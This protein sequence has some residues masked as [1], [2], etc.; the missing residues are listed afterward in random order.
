MPDFCGSTSRSRPPAFTSAGDAEKSKSGPSVSGQFGLS[1]FFARQPSVQVSFG[2][3]CWN[4]RTLPVLMS[5]AT[6][7]SVIGCGGSA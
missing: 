7:A 4:H 5:S 1:G 3:S 6:T 2:M